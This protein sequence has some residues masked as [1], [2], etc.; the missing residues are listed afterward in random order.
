MTNPVINGTSLLEEIMTNSFVN[1]VSEKSFP[2]REPNVILCP[3]LCSPPP[4]NFSLWRHL[5]VVV[6]DIECWVINRNH[7]W[8]WTT[9][10]N[11]NRDDKNTTDNYS[12]NKLGQSWAELRQALPSRNCFLL[13]I[14]Y[15]TFN[16]RCWFNFF[17]LGR[18]S[19]FWSHLEYWDHIHF[20]CL[21]HLI[22][23]GGL[24]L[25]SFFM[26]SSF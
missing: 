13:A 9:L 8:S 18:L 5:D 10:F 19:S 4:G 23:V 17:M 21:L 25:F 6:T 26:V 16:T 11:I 22:V 2:R 3:L 15:N 24:K 20:W 1:E 14:D 7:S 12:L